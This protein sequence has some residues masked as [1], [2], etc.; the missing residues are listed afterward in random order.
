[1]Q[2]EFN[3]RNYLAS[4]KVIN[5][6][7]WST[8]IMTSTERILQY[9]LTGVIITMW[10][11]TLIVIP[12]IISHRTSK[13][14]E[15]VRASETR[16]RELFDNTSSGVAI[17]E[18]NEGGKDFIFKDF[19]KAAE[20]IEGARKED[21]IGKSIY[22]VRPG[23]REFG[24]MD[25]FE[26][27]WRT[28]I[29]EHHPT[30]F[31]HDQKLAVWFE[32]FVYKLPTGEVVSVYDDITARKR[33]E[34][35][36]RESQQMFHSV[37]DTIPTRVFWKDLDSNYL[38]CNRPFALDAGL[39]SPEEIVGRNDFEMSWPEHAHLYRSDD[40][41]VMETGI[42][43]LGYEEPQT[44]PGG[45][46]IW[47]RTSK[48]P[49][50]D[51]KGQIKGVL[52]TYEDIT[53]HKRAD[54]ALQAYES[55]LRRAEVVAL[56]G[57]WEFMLGRDKAKASEGARI[58]YGLKGA[59]WSIPEVQSI[60]L[61][62]YRGMLDKALI[63][64]VE[65]GKPYNVEFKIRRPSDGKIIDIHSIAEYSPEKRVVFGVIQDI[66]DR[67]RAEEALLESNARISHLNDVLRAV[68]DVGSL[69]NR[70]KD[71]IEAV[72]RGLSQPGPNP[73]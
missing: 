54:D 60:P 53:V 2:I 17:F 14:A 29:P 72:E 41:L 34:D 44:T 30:S 3:G 71:P 58:I 50:F 21:T 43:R 46:T 56:F 49:L 47:L 24:L 73:W 36:L 38:G 31:Y 23:I 20:R 22:E 32:N 70:E 1:M 37:L 13:S 15:M 5:P 6:E 67:K 40:R 26:R 48:V 35:A 28:G 66:T 12:M 39:Q 18:A 16:Y 68:R 33:A 4:R 63:G 9:Q 25:V 45:D 19:N 10:I 57:N 62:E 51:V 59:E 27:V 42:A 65:E 64:L 11:C 55:R 7:G 69:I 52:G 61:P 8:V